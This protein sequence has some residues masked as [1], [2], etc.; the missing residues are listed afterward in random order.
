MGI[1]TWR[2]RFANGEDM[3]KA[4]LVS[5]LV[6]TIAAPAL[7]ARDPNATRGLKRMLLFLFCFNLLWLALLQVVY[8]RYSVPEWPQ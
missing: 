6:A 1:S 2:A 8:L 7:A 4:I 5:I 3:G